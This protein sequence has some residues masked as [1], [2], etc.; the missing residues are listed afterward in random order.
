LLRGVILVALTFVF[1]VT[2]KAQQTKTLHIGGQ[3]VALTSD[4]RST[5]A[6]VVQMPEGDRWYGTL[7]SGTAPGR[8]TV[9][10][11]QSGQWAGQVFSLIAPTGHTFSDIVTDFPRIWTWDLAFWNTNPRW[12]NQNVNWDATRPTPASLQAPLSGS[13]RVWPDFHVQAACSSITGTAGWSTGVFTS[14]SNIALPNVPNG[15][16]DFA[17]AERQCWC[18]LKR[19][20][21]GANGGWVFD[22]ANSTAAVCATHC[23]YSCAFNA[24]THAAFRAALFNA[25]VNP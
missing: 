5:P 21:D 1:A 22:F 17:S 3:V 16:I 9:Q 7:V 20:S 11:P 15:N 13:P 12:G 23:P 10:M 4:K 2:A 14:Q 6:L 8:L 18:R 24:A 25:F 19:R